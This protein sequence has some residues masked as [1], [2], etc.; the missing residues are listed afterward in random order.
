MEIY[1]YLVTRPVRVYVVEGYEIESE[2]LWDALNAVALERPFMDAEGNGY[3]T[4][5][6]DYEVAAILEQAG[7]IKKGRRGNAYLPTPLFNDYYD[8]MVAKVKE[9][10]ALEEPAFIWKKES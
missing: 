10:P 5:D 3:G 9:L 6:I 4:G 2:C 7:L 1:T 8:A